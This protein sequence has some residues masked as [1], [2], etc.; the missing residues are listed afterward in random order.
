MLHE[1]VSDTGDQVAASRKIDEP[2]EHHDGGSPM[3]HISSITAATR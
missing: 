1:N 3:T 2:I